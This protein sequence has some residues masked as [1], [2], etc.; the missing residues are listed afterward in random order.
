MFICRVWWSRFLSTTRGQGQLHVNVWESK[1]H[2]AIKKVW[3]ACHFP[4]LHDHVH[5]SCLALFLPSETINCIYVL[6]KHATVPL[7][8]HIRQTNINVDFLFYGYNQYRGQ[9]V[10]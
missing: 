2:R 10:S 7:S 6:F 3:V 4:Q 9:T 1:T 5:E 8:L